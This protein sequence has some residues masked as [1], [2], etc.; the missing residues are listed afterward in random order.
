MKKIFIC[1]I[2]MYTIFL[3]IA[4]IFMGGIPTYP[5]DIAVICFCIYI[6][7]MIP[8]G[9][10]LV[11]VQICDDVDERVKIISACKSFAVYALFVIII[12]WSYFKLYFTEG[13][14]LLPGIL[15]VWI[16]SIIA[17]IIIS[18]VCRLK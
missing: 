10:A 16:L 7:L 6:P 2:I 5:G 3:G 8:I 1:I 4:N 13:M 9:I 14:R 17:L 11:A 15:I 12:Y 18:K